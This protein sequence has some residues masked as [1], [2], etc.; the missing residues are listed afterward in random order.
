MEVSSQS[1]HIKLIQLNQKSELRTLHQNSITRDILCYLGGFC[2]A[3]RFRSQLVASQKRHPA[4]CINKEQLD[5]AALPVKVSER[6]D[7]R[8][9]DGVAHLHRAQP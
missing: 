9:S 5:A 7:C 6:S 8:M 4:P 2:Q 3:A 1:K